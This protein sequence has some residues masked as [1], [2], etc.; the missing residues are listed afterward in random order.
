VT[1]VELQKQGGNKTTS[2][3]ILI[4]ER[5]QKKTAY[6]MYAIL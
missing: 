5:K 4:T 3:Q 1:L 6:G 2:R